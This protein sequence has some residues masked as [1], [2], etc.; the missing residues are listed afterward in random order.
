ML[1]SPPPPH[2]VE[3]SYRRRL[4]CNTAIDTQ[5]SY[6]LEV[7]LVFFFLTWL[8]ERRFF[9]KRMLHFFQTC[10]TVSGVEACFLN[11]AAVDDDN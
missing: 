4:A 7:V 9:Q 3:L 6:D 10:G 11:E 5:K 8:A 1:S 2:F